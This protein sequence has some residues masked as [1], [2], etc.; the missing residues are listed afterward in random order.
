MQGGAALLQSYTRP[1]FRYGYEHS[2][3]DAVKWAHDPRRRNGRHEVG[4]R[5]AIR[6]P[7]RQMAN[8]GGDAK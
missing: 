7:C 8:H 5:R 2:L 3:A 4:G 1:H 6:K